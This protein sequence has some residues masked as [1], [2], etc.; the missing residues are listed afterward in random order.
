[1]RI[2][3]VKKAT[4]ANQLSLETR[5]GKYPNLISIVSAAVTKKQ[6]ALR[7]TRKADCPSADTSLLLQLTVTRLLFSISKT[8][9]GSKA[10]E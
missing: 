2:A 1:M 8:V 3:N 7:V 10:F 5:L 4:L 9:S 6:P